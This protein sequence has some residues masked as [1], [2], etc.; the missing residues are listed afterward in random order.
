M[1]AT[2]TT[3]RQAAQADVSR[4]GRARLPFSAWHLLL[5]PLALIFAIPLVWLLLSSVMSNAEIN[6]FPPALWPSRVD[7]GGYRYV[8]GNALFPRWFANSLIVSTVAVASNLLFGAFG[9]YAFAR[10]RFSGSRSLLVLMLA[11]MAIPFQLTMIPTFLVMKRLGL[12]DTLG[13]LIVP[14][15]VTPFAVFLLRQF[16]LS[17]PR[18]LEEAAWIDGCSRLRVLFRVVLPLSRPALSTV[19]ILTF[20]STWNDLTWPLIAINHDNQYTLQLGLATFQGQHHTQ[21]AA[22]MAGNVIT[23]LPVLLAF[24]G[25]QKAFIQSIT[26]SGLKG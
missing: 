8:L 19:A 23:V 10:M 25:A 11:T 22:V 15:L 9:G 21:W 7:L 12:I 13:A 5:A 17:L 16:F 4:R 6:R 20:L 1:T 3:P 26:S 2:V 24:V 18:E 14:S